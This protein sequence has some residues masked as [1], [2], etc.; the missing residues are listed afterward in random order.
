MQPAEESAPRLTRSLLL[1]TA[2]LSLWLLVPSFTTAQAVVTAQYD[3]ART[4]ANPN[5]K[6]LNPGT[7]YVLARTKESKGLLHSD[8]YK[9]RLHA[10]A[11]TTGAE[12]FGGPVEIKASVKGIGSGHSGGVVEFNPQTENPRAA[13]L[14]VKDS[15]YL[16]WGSSC[17]IGPYHGWLMAYDEH[18]LAQEAV[19]D[20][21][22]DA[23]DSA[24]W[25]G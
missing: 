5:E 4:G 25:Q 14:L 22:P 19:F 8:E 20:T 1:P 3:N 7:L 6:I 24:I 11:V 13:L 21:S 2:I 16:S 23:S 18:P 10:L 12:K 9:Q 17:D 15:I